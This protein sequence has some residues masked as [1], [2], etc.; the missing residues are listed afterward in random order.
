MNLNPCF[1]RV[2]LVLVWLSCGIAEAVGQPTANPPLPPDLASLNAQFL[3]LESERV[4]TPYQTELTQLLNRHSERINQR[5]VEERGSGNLDAILALESELKSLAAQ[6]PVPQP[7][8]G[9]V[10]VHPSVKTIRALYQEEY[11][12]IVAARVANLNSLTVPLDRRLALME[13]EFTKRNRLDDAKVIRSYRDA[14]ARKADSFTSVE[15]PKITATGDFKNSLGMKF[16]PVPGTTVFFCIHETRR[17]DY[18]AYADEVPGVPSYWKKAEVDGNP[19]GDKDDHPA[20]SVSWE[21]AQAFCTWLSKRENKVYRLP[22][23]REW[24][25]AVGIGRDENWTKDTTP[26]SLHRRNKKAFPWGTHRL[27]VDGAGNF[28]DTCTKQVLPNRP[29]IA[30]Y[31][32]GFSTTAP[33]MSFPPN[34]FGLYDLGGNVWEWCEDWWNNAKILHVLRGGAWIV[35]VEEQL[36]SSYRGTG[37]PETHSNHYG[38]RCVVEVPQK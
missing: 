2:W 23:D 8:E 25:Y 21:D 19:V 3:K 10:L 32:D 20:V 38:F 6:E 7:E 15:S 11:A 5:I 33:V 34:K 14:L 36:L 4:T 17:S 18:A 24:S 28:A 31:T 35:D 26:E 12:R 13:A 22:T 27:P 1:L 9:G 16:L 37:K 29:F 30:G